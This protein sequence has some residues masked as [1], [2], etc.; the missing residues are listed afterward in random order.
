MVRRRS[1]VRRTA[2]LLASMLAVVPL[3]LGAVAQACT[4]LPR[5]F[6]L[7]PK[8]A[9]G[10]AL[11]KAVGEGVAPRSP[12]EVRWDDVKGDLIG[13]AV[14][15]EKGQFS[16]MVAIPPAP[17]GAH[18]VLF[19]ARAVG[20]SGLTTVGRLPFAV[21]SPGELL[22]TATEAGPSRVRMATAQPESSGR[23]PTS[24]V[25]ALVVGMVALS[26]GG[27]VAVVGRRRA[28]VDT[29]T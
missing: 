7:I 1:P 3:T 10:A 8:S 25:L 15:D 23:G 26:V 6:G 12:V 16:A 21:T 9:S 27:T 11:A 2:L 4:P 17:P 5:S 19:R 29:T 20:T 22:P 14:A 13:S 24:G 18:A 28:T